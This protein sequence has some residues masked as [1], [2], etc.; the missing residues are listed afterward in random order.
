MEMTMT[1]SISFLTA[2]LVMFATDA[3]AQGVNLTG[4]YRCIQLCQPGFETAPAYVT[5]NG[6]ELN[7]IDE[8]G[9]A[10]RAHIDW[11]GKIWA[12]NWNEGAVFSPDGMTIQFDRGRVWQR[13]LERA[14]D[15]APQVAAPRKRRVR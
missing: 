10:S 2:A 6:W 12:S 4:R 3:L 7:M 15:I 11:W 8:A 1:R 5:Q 14:L 13:A 9:L